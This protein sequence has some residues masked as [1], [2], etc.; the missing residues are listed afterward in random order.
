MY[1]PSPSVIESL[2]P[3]T[4]SLCI[5]LLN[6][7]RAAGV[8]LIASSGRR[9]YWEELQLYWAGRSRTLNSRHLTGNAFDV[10][11]IGWS[12]DALPLAFWN[13]LGPYGE[14][15]GLKWGGRWVSLRDLGHFET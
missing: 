13:A 14:R 1:D 4:A 7:A 8:P 3:R 15:L 11:V 6:A 10:D 5:Q 9:S 12:R 2:E